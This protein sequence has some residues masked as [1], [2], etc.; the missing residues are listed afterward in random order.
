MF[1]VPERVSV[2]RVEARKMDPL[3]GNIYNLELNPPSDEA[4]TKRLVSL[5]EDAP[6][7]VKK[8]YKQFEDYQVQLEDQFKAEIVP[9]DANRSVQ[10]LADHLADALANPL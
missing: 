7:I 9:V 5:K 10:E 4:V 8:K 3:T 6:A 2:K 1:D